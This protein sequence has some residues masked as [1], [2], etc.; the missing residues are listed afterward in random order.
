MSDGSAIKLCVLPTNS[1]NM[2]EM[3][4]YEICIYKYVNI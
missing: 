1:N 2:G 3:K 4:G